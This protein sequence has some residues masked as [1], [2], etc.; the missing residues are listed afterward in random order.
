M[1][2]R[3]AEADFKIGVGGPL[4][5]EHLIILHDDDRLSRLS[6]YHFD[7]AGTFL[8]IDFTKYYS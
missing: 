6:D 5:K 8:D 7:G 4:E 3:L 2:S 1:T